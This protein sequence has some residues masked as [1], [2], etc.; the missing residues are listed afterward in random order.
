MSMRST[1]LSSRT[2]AL[3]CCGYYRVSTGRQADSDLSIPD[4]RKQVAAF[5]AGKGW[6]LTAD[7]V[8]AGASA[9]DDARA[10]FQKMIE[11]ATDDD[12]PYGAVIVHSYSRFFRDSFGLEMYIRKLAKADVRLISITQELGEDPAQIMMR[13][14]IALFDEYQS[15]ENGK[16]VLRA[17]KEN[18]R[19]GF[20]N[21]SPL[22]L[23]YTTE[24]VEK[25]GI[26][27]KKKIVIDP[28]EAETITRIFQLYKEGDGRDG[29]IGVKKIAVWLNERGYRTRLGSRF[30]VGGVHKILTNEA[31]VGRATFNKRSSKTLREK[32]AAEHIAFDIPAIVDRTLFDAVQ[33][34]LQ[35][36]NPRAVA[37]RV[38]S[39]PILL[40]GL[41]QC[42]TCHGA[43]TLRTGTSKSGTVHRY[44]TC[45]TC[46]RQGKAACK[47]RSIRMD[48]LDTLVVDHLQDR[49]F[50]PDRLNALLGSMMALRSERAC[51]VDTRIS[52][53][54]TE[55]SDAEERLKRLYQMVEDGVTDLDDLLKERVGALKHDRDRAKAALDRIRETRSS[56]ISFDPETVERFGRLMREN[57]T[58]GAIP[59]RKAYLQ[60]IVERIEVDD[61]VVR[62]VGNTATLEQ[63]IAGGAASPEGVRRSVPKWRARRDSNS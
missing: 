21:G 3:I 34:T 17:M 18:A 60:A 51:E 41:A 49:L 20:Y 15:R 62:I 22:P 19:Q 35:A 27:I 42:A 45:S 26:R 57:I 44:Y 50:Q 53:L 6:E 23:G 11:R 32:P 58:N 30:G 28:V 29:P 56:A 1:A 38:L 14:V 9:T 4:Q 8:E 43:M 39:G 54:Q 12:R 31:Y 7:Y 10:E 2:P 37:P 16:H 13:Q 25:R 46:A 40:T 33:A 61:H 36:H 59:F 48:R 24:D 63:A 52:R 5:C 47:G 55:I